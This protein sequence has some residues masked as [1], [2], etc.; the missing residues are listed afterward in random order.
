MTTCTRPVSYLRLERYEL[1]ELPPE[2]HRRVA[3]HLAQC[4]TCRACHERLQADAREQ[5]VAALV[6]TLQDPRTQPRAAGGWRSWLWAPW[7]LAASA[8]LLLSVVV[9]EQQVPSRTPAGTKGDALAIELTRIDA[10]GALLD[11]THFAP[12][13][14]FKIALTCPP[15]LAG[16]VTVFVFQEGEAFA[17]FRVQRLE[18][19]GNRRMLQGALELDGETPVEVCVALGQVDLAA[20][21]SPQDLPE[22]HVC[23]RLQP[24]PSAIRTP[25]PAH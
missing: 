14:R 13:D 5:D 2:E 16:Q 22:T 17:P 25:E 11:P 12:G 4:A 24:S 6:A 8:L 1:R 20:V 19:C 3:E 15:Q 21:R 23:S 7:A 18:S 10:R 9:S